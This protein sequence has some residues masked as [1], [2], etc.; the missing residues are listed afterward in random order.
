MEKTQSN[1]SLRVFYKNSRDN[2]SLVE[3]T[4][5]STDITN[6]ILALLESD[7]KGANIFLCYYPFGSEIDLLPLYETLLLKGKELYFPVSDK[8]THMLTFK[9]ISHLR[10]DFHKG[11]YDIMEPNDGL[12]VFTDY[13][14][15]AITPGLVFDRNFNR[16]GYGGGFYDRFFSSHPDII[17]IAPVFSNLL[18]DKIPVYEHDMPMDYIVTYNEI[19]KGDR[20]C[21]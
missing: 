15:I 18:I 13:K 8:L 11:S 17:R 7:F 5:E 6:N 9:K 1:N 21:H 19:L 14:A 2:M 20:L 12:S 10:N 16:I 3:H 4:K